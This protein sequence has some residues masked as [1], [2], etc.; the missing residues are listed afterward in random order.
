MFR[1]ITTIFLLII[2]GPLFF[3]IGFSVARE[4]VKNNYNFEFFQDSNTIS[5]QPLDFEVYSNE[6]EGIKFSILNSKPEI[7]YSTNQELTVKDIARNSQYKVVV[8]GGF[9][10]NENKHAGLLIKDGEILTKLAPLDKQ[11]SHIINITKPNSLQFF[12]STSKLDYSLL[13]NAFQTGP[14][15]L[16]DNILQEWFIN[17]SVNGN[18]EYLRTFIGT[19]DDTQII[20]G[21]TTKPFTLKLL[22]EELN[23]I[24]SGRELTIVNLDGGSSVVYFIGENNKD[25]V[26]QFKKLPILLGFK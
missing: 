18:G 1:R 15:I 4:F 23:R 7:V 21:I 17:R 5:T 8:N 22:G 9:F 25:N 26:G 20:V 19:I 14:I 11:L 16:K 3:L 13:V 10:T 24:L 6:N 2:L 12:E